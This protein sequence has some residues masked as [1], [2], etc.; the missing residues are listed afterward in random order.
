MK[1]LFNSNPVA[2]VGCCSLLSTSKL[3]RFFRT[4]QF[5]SGCVLCTF[6]GEKGQL[7]FP[8]PPGERR[9]CGSRPLRRPTTFLPAAF[10]SCQ[11]LRA[12]LPPGIL[13]GLLRAFVSGNAGRLPAGLFASF[14]CLSGRGGS[15]PAQQNYGAP[16]GITG[17]ARSRPICGISFPRHVSPCKCLGSALVRSSGGRAGLLERLKG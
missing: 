2:Q 4:W 12:N 6:A 11:G 13:A 3:F 5:I 9:L 15:L 7:A 16:T 17:F 8:G 1:T 10:L 14:G